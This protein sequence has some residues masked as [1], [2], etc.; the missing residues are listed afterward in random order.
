MMLKID[1]VLDSNNETGLLIVIVTAQLPAM[2]EAESTTTTLSDDT[3]LQD[4]AASEQTVAE[5][6]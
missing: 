1:T 2:A 5:Q 6:L 4:D 3:M